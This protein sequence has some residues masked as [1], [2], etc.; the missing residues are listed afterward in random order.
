MKGGIAAISNREGF[1]IGKE[2]GTLGRWFRLILGLYLSALVTIVPLL[3]DPASTTD[4]VRFLGSVGAYMLVVLAIYMLAFYL[5]GERVL[6]STDPW[7]GALIFL[8]PLVLVGG[9][10]LGPAAFQIAI[11]LYYS[12]SSIFN[13]A[14]SYGGCEVVAIPSLIFRKRYTLYCPYNAV[15]IVEKS[16]LT[17]SPAET[18]FGLLSYT[19]AVLVGGFFLLVEDQGVMRRFL[20][21]NLHNAWA[22]LLLIPVS[23]LLR[24]AWKAFA[25][26]EGDDGPDFR[27]YALGAS[28]LAVLTVVFVIGIDALLLWPA[29]MLLGAGY[30]GYRLLRGRPATFSS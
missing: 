24:N 17:G 6:A 28:V 7:I 27:T 8:G 20:D 11:G 14:M 1:V 9:L 25:E 4:T 18:A 30:G 10:G 12:I 5:L 15:D 26:G 3:D 21:L 2:V 13:F 29:A 23:Y 16:L 22:L 19:I